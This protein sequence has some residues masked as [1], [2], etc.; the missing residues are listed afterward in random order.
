MKELNR[1]QINEIIKMNRHLKIVIDARE[2]DSICFSFRAFTDYKQKF[3]RQSYPTKFWYLISYE[4]GCQTDS[5]FIT[6]L[7]PDEAAEII[8]YI[9]SYIDIKERREGA[10]YYT[11]PSLESQPSNTQKEYE[12]YKKRFAVRAILSK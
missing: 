8:K 9:K 1:L 11:N 7:S 4:S 3:L 12:D 10:Y 6:G 5:F 2:P